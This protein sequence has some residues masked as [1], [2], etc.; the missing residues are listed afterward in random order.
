MIELN[1]RILVWLGFRK[2]KVSKFGCC[3]LIRLNEALF[4]SLTTLYEFKFRHKLG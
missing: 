4:G 1:M 2:V 3:L